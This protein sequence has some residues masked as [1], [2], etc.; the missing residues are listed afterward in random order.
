VLK[1]AASGLLFRSIRCV[2]RGEVWVGRETMAE[3]LALLAASTH[4]PQAAS[5]DAPGE[6]ESRGPRLTRREGDVLRLVVAGE[7]NKGIASQLSIGEDTVKHHLTS[8]FD[9]TGASNRLELA[10]FALHHRL[11]KSH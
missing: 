1:D 2:H 7:T 8:I 4:A 9:K 6:E 10:L 5:T 3:V 11:V